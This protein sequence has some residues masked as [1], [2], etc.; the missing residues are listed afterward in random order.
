MCMEIIWKTKTRIFFVS[1]SFTIT[2]SSQVR[3]LR[4]VTVRCYSMFLQNERNCTTETSLTNSKTYV[5]GINRQYFDK[6]LTV[7]VLLWMEWT[8][9]L[10][11]DSQPE[12][13]AQSDL[14]STSWC[15]KTVTS[16]L[17]HSVG[18]PHCRRPKISFVV[19]FVLLLYLFW[20][21]TLNAQK[22]ILMHRWV[23]LLNL[24]TR[25]FQELK[26]PRVWFLGTKLRKWNSVSCIYI[27]SLE[28]S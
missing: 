9:R 6:V 16:Q 26:I 4:N 10:E 17:S 20:N 15:L 14:R 25:K 21:V 24:L 23:K 7:Y 8:W 27:T 1:G 12:S 13:L 3:S 11:I 28:H 22:F 5:T 19:H 2:N 18:S